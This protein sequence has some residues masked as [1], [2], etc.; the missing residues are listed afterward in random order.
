[1]K[2]YLIRAGFDPTKKYTAKDYLL[3]AR[4]IIG[5]NSGNLLYAYGVMNVLKT[6]EVEFDCLY[7]VD[8]PELSDEE[9]S[10]INETYD[11]FIVPMADAFREAYI[12]QLIWYTK[13][14]NRL[15]IPVV[16]IGIGVRAPYEPDFESSFEFDEAARDF[17]SSV[18]NH[19]SILGLRG[20]LTGKYLKKLGFKEE[21]HFTAIGCPSLYT[22]GDC[23]SKHRHSPTESEINEGELL[24][25]AHMTAAPPFL[26][27]IS[28]II[29]N[30]IRKTKH[31][32]LVQQLTN[33][34]N[35]IYI[36][37]HFLRTSIHCRTPFTVE[38]YSIMKKTDRVKYFF[39][40][41]S[42]IEFAKDFTFFMGCRFHGCV[43]A[44]LSGIPY[45]FFPFNARTREL[46][47][48]H[49]LTSITPSELN[50]RKSIFDY[51]DNLDF[52]S[53][54][55]HHH[56]NFYHYIDFLK[57]NDLDNIFRE[58][59]KYDIGESPMEKKVKIMGG[60][61]CIDALTPLEK[62]IRI[63]TANMWKIEN[64]LFPME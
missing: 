58:K 29:L 57:R 60:I 45:V 64:K 36:G 41:P 40:V 46:S 6:P 43:A 21:T 38:E 26:D 63:I 55:K 2:K 50:S 4:H 25:N 32:T 16:V 47:D 30:T 35:D 54:E 11:A 22:Y 5:D 27:T 14:I 59:D 53:L 31:H 39:D 17:V 24:F 9:V 7:E 33:E 10:L 49:H 13:L 37:N 1:M 18:L 8:K 44:I 42:W 34:F 48:Y 20:E 51:L 61:N 28:S 12:R 62:L 15:K 19:S 23:F 56:E 52:N 3:N